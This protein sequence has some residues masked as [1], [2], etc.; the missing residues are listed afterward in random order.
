MMDLSHMYIRQEKRE[1]E[2]DQGSVEYYCATEREKDTVK[3]EV[4]EKL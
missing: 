4:G 3:L 1:R 2:L